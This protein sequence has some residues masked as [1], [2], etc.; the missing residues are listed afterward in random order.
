MRARS[1]LQGRTVWNVNATAT[2]GGVAEMLQALLA[3]SRGA[4]IDTRWLVLDGTPDFFQLTK[5]IHNHLHGSAGDAGRLGDEQRKIYERVLADNLANLREQIRAGDI[6]ILHDPQTAGLVAG[7]LDT[8]AHVVWRCHVGRDTPT[9][10]TDGA[11]DFLRP[12][13]EPAEAVI[14]SRQVYAPDWV[15]ASR[16]WV[17]PPSLDPFSTKNRDLTEGRGAGR[18]PASGDRADPGGSR[19]PGVRTSRWVTGHRS[20][21]HRPDALR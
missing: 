2:G 10:L 4:Q 8:G 18:A 6:V 12:Y 13:V 14:F 20:P 21:P 17:I 5:R 1:L 19:Q 9:E 16:L 11:W 7:L 3:Y 15:D